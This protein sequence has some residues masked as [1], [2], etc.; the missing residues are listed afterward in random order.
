MRR[1]F[2]LIEMLVVIAIISI[3]AAM[4]SP[5][6][7]K[8]LEAA[9]SLNCINNLKQVGVA[10]NTYAGDFNGWIPGSQVYGWFDSGHPWSGMLTDITPRCQNGGCRPIPIAGN[11]IGDTKL[12]FCPSQYFGNWS[13]P[14]YSCAGPH[15]DRSWYN[16]YA[17]C[18]VCGEW[19]QGKFTSGWAKWLYQPEI[20]ID[21]D[22]VWQHRWIRLSAVI[23]P[24]KKPLVG[25]SSC[26]EGNNVTAG[27]G[28]Y[29]VFQWQHY[30]DGKPNW[31]LIARH[32]EKVNFWFADGHGGTVPG[33]DLKDKYDIQTFSAANGDHIGW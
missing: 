20:G 23:E 4:M 32:Q 27:P 28:G 25:D 29:G 19:W 5:S 26:N 8:A 31:S 3:L 16:T 7:M 24:S 12:F 18:G 17:M 15:W 33:Y 30:N 6:L 9:R 14:G 10:L 2:T 21:G 22:K 11:Y 1:F 13:G